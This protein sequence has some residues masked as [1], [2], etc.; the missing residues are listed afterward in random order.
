MGERHMMSVVKTS[1]QLEEAIKGNSDEII[2]MGEQT[3]KI[4]QAINQ[5]TEPVYFRLTNRFDVLE[6]TDNSQ[7]V[8]G[9]LYRK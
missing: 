2:I 4:M 8:Q 7:Q 9:I 1:Q 3:T 6:L 5:P